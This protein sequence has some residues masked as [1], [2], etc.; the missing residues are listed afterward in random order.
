[1]RAFTPPELERIARALGTEA[2]RMLRRADSKAL[3]EGTE[4][5]ANVR[6]HCQDEAASCRI[7][8]D[9]IRATI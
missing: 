8:R 6:R 7:L 1:M 3:A 5:A 2:D 9:E 4:V